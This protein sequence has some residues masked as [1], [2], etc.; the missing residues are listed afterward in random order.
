VRALGIGTVGEF[1]IGFISCFMISDQTIIETQS[2]LPNEEG[3]QATVFN[4][5][6]FLATEPVD[7]SHPGTCVSLLLKPELVASFAEIERLVEYW[8][9]FLELPIIVCNAVGNETKLEVSKSGRKRASDNLHCFA[10]GDKG[11]MAAIAAR[12]EAQTKAA[13]PS[14]YQDGLAIPDVSPPIGEIP[15]QEILRRHGIRL[16]LCGEDRLP[17]DLSRNLVEGGA[18]RLWERFVPRIWAGL[19]A[20]GLHSKAGRVAFSGYIQAEFERSCGET[21]FF[22]GPSGQLQVTNIRNCSGNRP[23]HLIDWDDRD[24]HRAAW[25]ALPTLVLPDVPEVLVHGWVLSRDPLEQGDDPA[26]DFWR[27]LGRHKEQQRPELLDASPPSFRALRSYREQLFSSFR[28]VSRSESSLVKLDNLKSEGAIELDTLGFWRLSNNWSAIR[29]PQSGRWELVHTQEM[30]NVL[31]DLPL[32][33]LRELTFEQYICLIL[34]DFWPE[35][36]SWENVWPIQ[37][38]T[39]S[40]GDL[41]VRALERS[42]TNFDQDDEDD[43]D[44]EDDITRAWEGK[45]DEPQ[46]QQLPRQEDDEDEDEDKDENEDEDE[47]LEKL[48]EI[49]DPV[50]RQRAVR[51]RSYSSGDKSISQRLVEQM[52]PHFDHTVLQNCVPPWDREHWEAVRQSVLASKKRPKA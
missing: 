45:L 52:L 30:E 8:G 34:Y 10:V 48:E 44:D 25:S 19:V 49:D 31:Y 5:R 17:L 9:P 46:R 29:N 18:E 11:S 24:L 51:H 27:R 3:I 22:I 1:G 39:D 28:F 33:M 35:P 20:N 50:E 13:P 41:V 43:E 21:S 7:R 6:G 47:F 14:L 36:G 12:R 2:C 38:A 4:W 37:P 32:E 23:I 40:L 42:G 26:I 15:N 16:N